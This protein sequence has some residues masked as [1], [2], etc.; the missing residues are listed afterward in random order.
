MFL[1]HVDTKNP[2]EEMSHVLISHQHK[3]SMHMTDGVRVM[4]LSA[5]LLQ[6]IS[7][8]LVCLC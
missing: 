8:A 1:T 2:V 4:S 6:K 7:A 5:S 3:Q